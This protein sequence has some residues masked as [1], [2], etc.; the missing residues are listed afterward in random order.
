M[1]KSEILFNFWLG[2]KTKNLDL[3]LFLTR[4]R[5]ERE[6]AKISI[7]IELKVSGNTASQ[8]NDKA[9]DEV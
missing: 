9:G 2:I 8:N 4:K 6:K 5:K 3:F 7:L 1:E